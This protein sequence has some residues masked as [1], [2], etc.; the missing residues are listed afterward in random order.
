[1]SSISNESKQNH[2]TL[3]L[4]Q[5]DINNGVV[6]SDKCAINLCLTRLGYSDFQVMSDRVYIGN[7]TY[8]FDQISK[9]QVQQYDNKLSRKPVI[10]NAYI[11]LPKEKDKEKNKTK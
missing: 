1:M 3:I 10:L 6:K 9:E 5:D 4:D 11:V 2:L 7:T 8:W